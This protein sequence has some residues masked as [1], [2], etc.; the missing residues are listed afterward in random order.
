VVG[1]ARLTADLGPCDGDGLE[2]HGRA[3]LDCDG[4]V[5]QGRPHTASPTDDKGDTH[6]IVLDDTV[7][8]SVRHCRVTGFTYGIQL[9]GARDSEVVATESFRNGDFHTKVG[10][11]IHLSHSQ[12]NAIRDCKV[13][14]N[15]DEGIHIGTDSDEN[16][17][18]TNEAWD[19]GREN[20]YILSARANRLLHNQGRGTMSANLYVKHGLDNVIEG[21][22]FAERPVVVRGRSRGNTFA[23]NL[24]GGGLKLEAYEEPQDAPS[25]NVVRGGR[26]VGAICLELTEAR[27]NRI[28][29]VSLDGCKGI[30]ARAIRPATNHLLGIDVAG[31]RLDLAGGATLRLLTP[32]RV[33][34]RDAEG[35]AVAG[36][37]I[38]VRDATGDAQPGPTTDAAGAARCLVPTH[39]INAA[40]LIPL[41]PVTLTLRADGFAESRTVLTDPLASTVTVTLETSA[42]PHPVPHKRRRTPPPST[43]LPI[44]VPGSVS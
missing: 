33:Q 22:R 30:A 44:S 14:E 43:S 15:A 18:S 27:D 3:V 21:N 37:H 12:R 36:A 42:P 13:H 10:Y 29:E 26:L 5:L 34:A 2:L 11:G 31:V 23:D 40:G 19:N 20:F 4:H 32:V 25:N 35:H 39:R 41:T 16:T 6:G 7:G 28:E 24:F 38:E 1:T 9:S 17:L 8:A